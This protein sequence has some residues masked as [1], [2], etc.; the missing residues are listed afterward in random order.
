[1]GFIMLNSTLIAAL[2]AAKTE[3]A[4][5]KAH[6]IALEEQIAAALPSVE[7]G[8]QSTTNIDCFKVVI[9][10]PITYKIDPTIW[11]AIK[12]DIPLNKRPVRNKLE[13]DVTGLKWLAENDPEAYA[14]AAQAITSHAGK[15]AVT[16][17]VIEE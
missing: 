17:T 6:R 9:K 8:S 15:V 1:M 4:Q 10:A 5:A 3:E 14:I 16:A 7:L 2:I 11:D 12:G 13:V